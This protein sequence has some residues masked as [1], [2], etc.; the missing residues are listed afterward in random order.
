MNDENIGPKDNLARFI[1]ENRDAFDDLKAPSGMFDKIMPR[2]NKVSP[3]WKW[4]A[5]AASALLLISVGY[6]VGTKASP[7][8]RIAGYT[9]FQEAE[10]Y[11]QGRIDQKMELIKN[12]P[13]HDEVMS[14]IK[15]LDEVYEQ[16]RKQLLDD[17]NADSKV[18]L[19]AM[20]KHQKQKLQV[21]DEILQ[22]VEKYKS[23]EN[24]KTHEM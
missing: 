9:E 5:V 11:Y 19:H 13:V 16:L 20:I 14:D 23:T 4:M 2:D 8:S 17:P 15:V 22:R 7:E 24:I 12:L 18:L 1:H 3:L 10:N 21:M 6:M